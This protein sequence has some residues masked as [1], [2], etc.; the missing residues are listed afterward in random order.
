MTNKLSY[1]ELEKKIKYL[2]RKSQ[3]VD[4]LQNKVNSDKLFLQIMLDTMPNPVFYKDIQ[5]NY[6]NCNDSFS[7]TILGI[8]KEDIIG[9]S[10]FD[11]PSVIPSELAKLY[12]KKDQVLFDNPGTQVYEGKVKCSDGITRIFLFNKATVSDEFKNVLGIVGI[13]LDI[14]ELKE[15]QIKLDEKNKE[16]ETLSY[17]DAL[18]GLLNRRRFDELFIQRIRIS[19]RY[20][21]VLNFAIIDVDNFKLYND[22]YGHYEGDNVLKV[23]SRT[24]NQRLLRPDDY[25]FRLGGEEFGLLYHTSDEESSLQLIENIRSDVENLNIEHINNNDFNKV[26][27]SVGIAVVKN[28]IDDTKYIY[29]KADSLLYQAKKTGRNKVVGEVI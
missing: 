1:E 21:Y 17:T 6:Q 12:H 18:T 23:L 24:I 9:K 29:E 8:S 26:T 28:I 14:T 4:S 15:N 5:G 2:E 10:L 20:K 19:K 13:M 7:K 27:I 3:L 25:L 11:L 22:N 16:L